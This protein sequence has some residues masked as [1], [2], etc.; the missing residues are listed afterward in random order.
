MMVSRTG[1]LA[2]WMLVWAGAATGASE[3]APGPPPAA[4]AAPTET[5]G[6]ASDDE[7]SA[8]QEMQ[9]R[10][11]DLQPL[12]KTGA[13]REFLSAA[14][15]LPRIEKRVLYRN[16]AKGVALTAA[17]FAALPEGERADLTEFPCDET[18]YYY[19]GYGSPLMYARPLD[20]LAQRADLGTF[21]G[22]TIVDFGYGTVGHLRMLASLGAQA[23]GIEV[24]PVLKALYSQP[25]DTGKIRACAG[26]FAGAGTGVGEHADGRI[27]LVD[28]RFPADGAAVKDVR[29]GGPAGGYDVFISKNTLKRGYIHPA[30]AVDERMLVKLGVEDA[31]FC[32]SVFE[33]LK[34]GGWFMIYNLCPAQNPEDKPYL[35]HADGESPFPRAMLEKAGFEVVE[36]D[37]VDTESA[38]DYWM[39]LGFNAGKPRDEV[40]KDLRV[41]WTLCRRPMER[42]TK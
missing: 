25:G 5:T 27:T 37:R 42:A 21:S 33:M 15:C 22:L 31:Q 13:A 34:P 4:Q 29:D 12:V 3:P 11:R 38:L 14:E 8:V 23:T 39:A 7:E 1:A 17:E 9:S 24:S 16:R 35:P 26:A 41:W 32:A 10:A 19:T 20:L 28:G 2:A 40:A 30:R 18:F 6:A 36:F